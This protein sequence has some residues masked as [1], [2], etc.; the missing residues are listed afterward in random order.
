[1]SQETSNDEE[2]IRAMMTRSSF[3]DA[4]DDYRQADLD[5]IVQ[6]Y[7]PDAISMPCNHHALFDHDDIRAWYAKRTGEG[8]ER[9]AIS[10]V[11]SVDVVG[12]L[13]IV[14]GTF[15]VTR[16]PEEGVAALDHGGRYLAVLRRIDGQWRMWRDMDQ[17]SPDA[18]K[19]YLKQPR[20]W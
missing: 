11:D 7:A 17:T 19:Y 5:A 18:D 10:D 9:N 6:W 20:G 8:H 3:G 14:V 16:A 1:M 15:R 2:Q 4:A 13:A 12:D